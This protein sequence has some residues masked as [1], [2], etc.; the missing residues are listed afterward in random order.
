VVDPPGQ[1]VAAQVQ[2]QHDD[3]IVEG[4]SLVEELSCDPEF[5]KGPADA[6]VA[7]AQSILGGPCHLSEV[8][9][10]G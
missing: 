9:D 3:S 8:T 10:R 5:L 1:L 6:G 2:R 7:Q 4:V